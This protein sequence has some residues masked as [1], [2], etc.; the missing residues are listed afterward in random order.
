[1]GSN[2][3][4][5]V[6]ELIDNAVSSV[7]SDETILGFEK[8]H[9]LSKAIGRIK[10]L[11]TPEYMAPIMNLQGNKLGFKTDK[12]KNGG[13]TQDVVRNCLVE[14]VLIGVPASAESSAETT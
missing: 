12:D 9:K 6:N 2:Q 4:E 5:A 3:I 1:M 7:I 10:E 8:A 14:A 13:Y 11:M